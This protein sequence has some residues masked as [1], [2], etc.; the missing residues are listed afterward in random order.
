M[1]A[2][3]LASNSNSDLPPITTLPVPDILIHFVRV[4]LIQPLQLREAG[5]ASKPPAKAICVVM[6]RKL[7]SCLSC[8]VLNIRFWGW[9]YFIWFVCL[10]VYVFVCLCAW[11][12]VWNYLLL[13]I[14]TYFQFAQID[15]LY[16][17][18]RVHMYIPLCLKQFH[19][20]KSITSTSVLNSVDKLRA[21]SLYDGPEH[22]Y[23]KHLLRIN[24]KPNDC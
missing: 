24:I 7:A 22:S 23:L 21:L 8:S 10:C 5:R 11:V 20:D 2:C 6:T 9:Y 12:S 14:L 16:A 15:T 1:C 18:V 3:L 19:C 4:T 17:H 13:T